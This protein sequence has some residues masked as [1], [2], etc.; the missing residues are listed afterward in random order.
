MAPLKQVHDYIR[1]NVIPYLA[2]EGKK[3]LSL[4]LKEAYSLYREYGYIPT[5]YLTHLLFSRKRLENINSFLP[6][7]MTR[8][9]QRQL[10]DQNYRNLIEDK[11][12]LYKKL[13]E[14]GLPT[15]RVILYTDRKGHIYLPTG[16]D[17]DRN[18]SYA[19]LQSV[20]RDIFAKPR[21]GTSGRGCKTLKM[22]EVFKHDFEFAPNMIYQP[23]LDQH[24]ALSRLNSTS[25]NTVRIDSTI[26]GDAV[27]QSA[28]VLRIG[29]R[30]SVVDNVTGAGGLCVKIDLET[31]RLAK[32]GF[33][34]LK[35]G[36]KIVEQAPDSNISLESVVV[37]HWEEV[38]DLV[39]RA[40]EACK[41]LVTLGW[42]VALTSD[43]PV[44]IEANY[45]WD[46]LVSQLAAGGLRDTP[47]G[48]LVLDCQRH[49]QFLAPWS[50]R[51]QSWLK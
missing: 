4:Q 14:C 42:D 22:Q 6:T 36:G 2:F 33:T 9:A 50:F 38:R 16:E 8:V 47:F 31:G 1:D 45:N 43:G 30:G 3:P 34:A 21:R 27:T 17:V 40:G 35:H 44:L 7:R 41:P 26:V 25:I 20:S 29:S 32:H 13:T 11:L 51:T 18:Q 28:A 23:Y 12:S 15:V 39:C 19:I 46:V 10:N 5:H 49:R 37:P 48:G 24:S